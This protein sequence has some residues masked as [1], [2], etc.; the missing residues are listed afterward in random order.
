MGVELG[1]GQRQ[2]TE[3][4]DRPAEKCQ[5]E[6]RDIALVGTSQD[7]WKEILVARSLTNLL[8]NSCGSSA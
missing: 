6:G 3:C 8:P 5:R 4:H 1:K 2:Q 7:C